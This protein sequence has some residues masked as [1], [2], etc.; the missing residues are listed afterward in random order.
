MGIVVN[1]GIGVLLCAR[2]VVGISD[3]ARRG[4]VKAADGVGTNELA[5]SGAAMGD[6]GWLVGIAVTSRG[7]SVALHEVGCSRR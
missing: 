1:S 4:I 5:R 3:A 2:L 6:W 7:G